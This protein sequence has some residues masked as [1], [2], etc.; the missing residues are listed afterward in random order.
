MATKLAQSDDDSA[1]PGGWGR[2]F[3]LAAACVV[4]SLLTGTA[5]ADSRSSLIFVGVRVVDSCRVNTTAA[6]HSVDVDIRCTSAARPSI[7]MEGQGAPLAASQ[8]SFTGNSP[9]SRVSLT[10]TGDQVLRIEF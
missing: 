5:L 9:V 7:R 2:W 6:K 10:R 4:S 8:G 3:P 1:K